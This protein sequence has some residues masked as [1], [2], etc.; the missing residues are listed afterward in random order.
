MFQAQ[1][2]RYINLASYGNIFFPLRT[3]QKISAYVKDPW[4]VEN[5]DYAQYPRLSTMD[6]SNNYR[7]SSFWYKNGD[8]LKLRSL[9]IGYTLASNLTKSIKL[10]EARI[11]LRGMNVLT[12][13]HFKYTDPESIS[14]YPAM[15]SYNIGLKVQF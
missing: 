6:N 13:D 4:T 5:K 12:V 10:S 15:K 3:N 9:E 2:D 8:F 11:F 1:L 7:N 14:G